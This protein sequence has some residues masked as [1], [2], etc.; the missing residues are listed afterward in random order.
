MTGG[1]GAKAPDPWQTAQSQAQFNQGAATTQQKLNLVDQITPY[2]SVTYED[3]TTWPGK[4]MYGTDVPKFKATTKLSPEMQALV[5]SGIMNATTASSLEGQL[6]ENAGTAMT[7]PLDL[8]WGETESKL[9]DL[10]K[11]TL[12]PQYA[13]SEKQMNQDL[14]NKGIA[15]GSE[16]W[17]TTQ[18]QFSD[19]KDR[20]YNDLYLRGHETAVNDIT[21][22]YTT[23]LNVLTALQTGSQVAQ[24]GVGALAPVP[25]ANVEA[26]DYTSTVNNNYKTASEANSA[27]LGGLFGLGGSVLGLA[28]KFIGSDREMKTDIDKLGKD[29]GTGLDMYAYRYKGDPKS[30]PKV[31]GPMAQDVE[32]K[33]PHAVKTVAGRKTIDTRRG[34][35]GIGGIARGR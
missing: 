1:G 29:A 25:Q 10:G 5:D 4:S 18:Q 24:P 33:D 13:A 3:D 31:V 26:P 32:K 11:K 17:K 19:A 21:S 14:Y 20:A 2:G 35:F 22:E 27:K 12:D 16:L 9:A 8:S 15:P 6:L 30:Y 34:S 7:K 28:G 23:P